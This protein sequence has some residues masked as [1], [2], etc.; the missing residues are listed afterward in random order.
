MNRAALS[1]STIGFGTA[2]LESVRADEPYIRALRN[3]HEAG[4][5]TPYESHLRLVT[6]LSPGPGIVLP[7]E[8]G[9]R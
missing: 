5:E 8:T 1:R 9:Q 7:A 6:W 4:Y 3:D 2:A